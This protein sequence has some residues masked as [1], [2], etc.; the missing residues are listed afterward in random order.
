ME[1]GGMEE[2][3]TSTPT[4]APGGF[5]TAVER[6]I[7]GRIARI[8]EGSPDELS[9]RLATFPRYA[10]RAQITRFAA[11]YELFK[12][13]QPVKG[14]IVDCGVFR[15][16]SLMAFAQFSAAL[17]PNNLTRRIYGFDTFD[18]FP[19]VSELD[20]PQQTG[21]VKGDLAADSY[22]ELSKLIEVYD[23]DRFL[24][25]IP[26]VRLVRGDVTETIPI[27]IADNPHLVVSMLFLDLDLFEPTLAALKNFLPKMP[28]GSI[29]A[30]DELDNPIWPGETL[31][32]CEEVGL[33]RLEL[34]RF[35]FD[36]YIAY[37]VL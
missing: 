14:S 13:A 10:R 23:S 11:L 17:E 7:P 27:F 3:V 5:Q 36:P 8:F 16:F 9:D 37:A 15:G 31:A 12:L 20:R 26:K 18:G 4:S 35:E 24:G 6:D 19:S 21:A 29:L 1:E 2:V 28:K 30:F 33:D 32:A 25:H 22:E 34:R